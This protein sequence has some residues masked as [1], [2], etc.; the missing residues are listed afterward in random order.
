MVL[1]VKQIV[2]KVSNQVGCIRVEL[3]IQVN[4]YDC[5]SRSLNYIILKNF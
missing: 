4:M 5:S 1:T 3:K 2:L